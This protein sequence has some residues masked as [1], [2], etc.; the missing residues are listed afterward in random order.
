MS[1]YC[2][3]YHSSRGGTCD[4]PSVSAD[5][6]PTSGA[7]TTQ[8]NVVRVI[9]ICRAEARKAFALCTHEDA[10]L[11]RNS[12]NDAYGLAEAMVLDR[13]NA[14]CWREEARKRLD[15][16]RRLEALALHDTSIADRAIAALGA[17]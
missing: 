3:Y 4:D 11:A 9:R 12:S 16:A 13:R 14:D 1:S 15:F 10:E 17:R 7:P 2:A 8:A 5:D 6:A